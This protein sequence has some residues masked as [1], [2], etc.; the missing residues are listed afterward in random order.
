MKLLAQNRP[1]PKLCHSFTPYAVFG[2][3][4]LGL[5]LDHADWPVPI[6]Q[7]QATCRSI[8]IAPANIPYHARWKQQIQLFQPTPTALLI[9][10]KAL[11][12]GVTA[13]ISYAEIAFDVLHPD[14]QRV[15]AIRNSFLASV[16]LH[17]GREEVVRDQSTYYFHRRTT[18]TTRTP[19]NLVLYAD[20]PSKLENRHHY[21][22]RLPSSHVEMKLSGSDSLEK[23]GVVSLQDLIRFNH[24]E[25]WERN[26]RLFRVPT[27]P[28]KLGRILAL[29]AGASMAVSG[30]AFRKR[31]N[32]WLEKH[33]IVH[34]RSANFV[35]H[36]ALLASP[37]VAQK[38]PGMTFDEWLDEALAQ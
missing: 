22:E 33:S 9:L 29:A 12:G 15:K 26:L 27:Q 20:K 16:K 2:Y 30:T 5:Y 17:Y 31:A 6:E 34:G 4:R 10:D 38:L 37:K 25:F 24:L 3:D 19:K 11:K 32:L 28:T 18:G 8:E 13:A 7:L 14:R 1:E 21:R 35:L 36:N 23:E